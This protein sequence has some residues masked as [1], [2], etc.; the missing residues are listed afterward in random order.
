MAKRMKGTTR[1]TENGATLAPWSLWLKRVAPP[2]G[3]KSEVGQSGCDFWRAGKEATCPRNAETDCK[4]DARVTPTG[5][6]TGTEEW[7]P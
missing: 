4:T 7:R 6:A 5:E 1:I 3:A 2:R